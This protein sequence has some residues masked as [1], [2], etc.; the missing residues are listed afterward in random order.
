MQDSYCGYA[1]TK[2]LDSRAMDDGGAIRRRR[3]CDSCAE[4]FTT[5]ERLDEIQLSVVKSDGTRQAFDRNKIVN[6]ILRSCEKRKVPSEKI[7]KVVNEIET[8]FLNLMKKEITTNEIG[9]LVMEKLKMLDE[10]AYV[11]F[12]SVYKQFKDIDT[13]LDELTKI[14]NDKNK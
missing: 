10:V 5:Y 2:V 13:F 3:M 14:L 8:H 4:K 1:D 12:A 11:R 9:E 6:G 7:E